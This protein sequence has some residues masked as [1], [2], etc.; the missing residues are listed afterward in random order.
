[1]TGP[2]VDIDF[3]GGQGVYDPVDRGIRAGDRYAFRLTS[4]Y[5]IAWR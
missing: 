1:M 3:L 4:G 2:V 5:L